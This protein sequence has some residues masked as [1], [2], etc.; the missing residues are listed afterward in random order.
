MT[1][2]SQKRMWI[3]AVLLVG[4]GGI[5]LAAPVPAQFRPPNP[6]IPKPPIPPG[7]GIPNRPGFPNPPV[8]FEWKCS[9]CNAVLGTGAIKPALESCPKCGVHFINGRHSPFSQNPPAAPPAMPPG[10]GNPPGFNPGQPEFPNFN[11]VG[12]PVAVQ[13]PANPVQPPN[14]VQPVNNPPPLASTPS[15]TSSGSGSSSSGFVW[16]IGI[17]LA[18]FCVV[19]VVMVLCTIFW[20]RF[21]MYASE[22][23][24]APRMRARP[25]VSR[26]SGDYDL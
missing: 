7:G 5:F 19:G 10:A 15:P 6:G 25:R 18:F 22:S 21:I 4:A 1:P 3:V 9:N 26:R 17:I 2:R 16:F 13:P 14:P 8:T 24:S 12:P 23:V 11:Q 20:I